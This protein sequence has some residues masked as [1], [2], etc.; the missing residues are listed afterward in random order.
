MS[1][2]SKLIAT[3][4]LATAHFLSGCTEGPYLIGIRAQDAQIEAGLDGSGAVDGGLDG[5]TRADGETLADANVDASACGAT[6]CEGRIILPLDTSGTAAW[7]DDEWRGGAPLL[8]LRGEDIT[9]EYWPMRSG[10][11]L[12]TSQAR[13]VG[14]PFSDATRAV[15]LDREFESSDLAIAPDTDRVIELVVRAPTGGGVWL[16]ALGFTLEGL[17]DGAIR[18]SSADA[19]LATRSLTAG[20]WYHLIFELHAEGSRVFVN[21]SGMDAPGFPKPS[22]PSTARLTLGPHPDVQLAWLA[23]APR[24]GRL[25]E[26]EVR[27]RF[28]TLTGAMPSGAGGSPLPMPAP[29]SSVAFLDITE[30]SGVRRWHLVGEDWPRIACRND[31]GGT[32]FCGYLAEAG[33]QRQLP[34]DPADCEALDATIDGAAPSVSDALP[35]RH[36]R[37]S[38]VMGRH[39]LAI[40]SPGGTNQVVSF[41]AR[42]ASSTQLA[43][44]VGSLGAAS[45]DLEAQTSTI[46]DWGELRIE[47]HGD[48]ILRCTLILRMVGVQRVEIVGV[49]MGSTEF[50][51]DGTT[52]FEIGGLQSE[53]NRLSATS[54]ILTTRAEDQL[55]FVADRNVPAGETASIRLRA[56][57]PAI[58][59]LHDQALVN[60]SQAASVD[61]QVN[62]YISVPGSVIFVGTQTGNVRWLVPAQSPIDGRVAALEA[63]WTARLASLRV[64]GTATQRAIANPLSL[65]DYDRLAVGFTSSTSGVLDGLLARL[66]IGP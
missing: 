53:G 48:G 34:L 3:G 29:R 63:T 62:L 35:M 59:R 7:S 33:A 22:P 41:F 20:A 9:P 12:M 13:S 11:G 36:V 66:E 58:P 42:A 65:A 47:D 27:E 43:V 2:P 4:L 44:S 6:S 19:T 32:R 57:T 18:L 26:L 64:D 38:A 39:G 5:D 25:S 60:I 23:V 1:I 52:L 49:Q 28:L 56:L 16:T 21:G 50:L 14:G 55:V 40:S 31:L 30:T 17:P 15:P 24:T 51:G 37:G 61:E 46:A 54:P 45:I 8:I 10:G